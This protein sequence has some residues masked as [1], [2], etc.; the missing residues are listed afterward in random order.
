MKQLVAFT[1]SSEQVMLQ[2]VLLLKEW[3]TVKPMNIIPL[4]L[5]DKRTKQIKRDR[6]RIK[7][8]L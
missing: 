7:I 6:D 1:F 8:R 5:S 4:T 3:E 2:A